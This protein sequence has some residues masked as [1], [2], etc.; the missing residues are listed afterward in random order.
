MLHPQDVDQP[1][2][3]ETNRMNLHNPHTV[4]SLNLFPIMKFRKNFF[5]S[6]IEH[7]QRE[8]IYHDEYKNLMKTRTASCGTPRIEIACLR[9][10]P[11]VCFNMPFITEEDSPCRQT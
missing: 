5:M 1:N 3:N 11:L 7:K 6:L 4:A 2:H 8:N 9:P 10:Q